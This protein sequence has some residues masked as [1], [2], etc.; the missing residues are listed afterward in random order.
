MAGFGWFAVALGSVGLYGLDEL[1]LP[2]NVSPGAELS[3][4]PF[5]KACLQTR[6][7]NLADQGLKHFLSVTRYRP[8]SLCVGV[9]QSSGTP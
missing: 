3:T 1:D 2:F 6:E 4:A 5:G 9:Q 7:H 8:V